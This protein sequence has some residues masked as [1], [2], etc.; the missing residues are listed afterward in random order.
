ML[1]DDDLLGDRLGVDGVRAGRVLDR[2]RTVERE[3]D[4]LG[5]E[6]GAVVELHALAELELP[7]EVVDRAPRHREARLQ[8]LVL[9]LV[10]QQ[11]DDVLADVAFGVRR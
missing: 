7:G 10:D 8:A 3:D 9:V 11:A 2:L 5:G 6:L 4:V 1:V